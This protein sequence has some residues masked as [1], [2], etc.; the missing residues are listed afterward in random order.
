MASVFHAPK[1]PER[2]LRCF[3]N[4]AD[5]CS[6]S[7]APT[8]FLVAVDA[9]STWNPARSSFEVYKLECPVTAC[10]LVLSAALHKNMQERPSRPGAVTAVPPELNVRVRGFFVI[11]CASVGLSHG[12]RSEASKHCCVESGRY[13]FADEILDR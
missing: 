10:I 11:S 6:L 5:L 9:P 12:L 4:T 1:P 2:S 8:N 13:F 7:N 3:L